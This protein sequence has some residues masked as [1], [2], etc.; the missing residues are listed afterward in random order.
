M[1]GV[2]PGDG[3]LTIGLYETDVDCGRRKDR[4]SFRRLDEVTKRMQCEVDDGD[5]PISGIQG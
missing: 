2:W 4:Y 3:R 1:S 5:L